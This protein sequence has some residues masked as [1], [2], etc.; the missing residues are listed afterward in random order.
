M[1]ANVPGIGDERGEVRRSMVSA[2]HRGRGV[3]TFSS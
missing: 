2:A 3:Q 1:P